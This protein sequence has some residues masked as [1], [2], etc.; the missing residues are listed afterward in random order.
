[1]KSNLK[2]CPCCDYF[3][4]ANRGDYEICTICFWED[5]GLDLTELQSHSGPNHLT[6]EEGR[7]NFLKFGA[8]DEKCVK[9]V[10]KE[11]DRCNFEYNKRKINNLHKKK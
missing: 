8:C 9:Y 3:T 11:L 4:L 2:Q 10:I 1:M 7:I 6:L 5:D